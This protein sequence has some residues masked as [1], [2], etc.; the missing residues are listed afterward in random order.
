MVMAVV[1]TQYKNFNGEDYF[2]ECLY[3]VNLSL[4]YTYRTRDK[5][6]HF[7]GNLQCDSCKVVTRFLAQ[8]HKPSVTLS[9]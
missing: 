2:R 9:S 5:I 7:I 6:L 4:Q 3:K 8:S 1:E